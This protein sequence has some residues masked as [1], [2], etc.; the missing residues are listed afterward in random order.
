M[1]HQLWA[2]L[3]VALIAAGAWFWSWLAKR[4]TDQDIALTKSCR[5][6]I[7]GR[8]DQ[9]LEAVAEA[10]YRKGFDDRLNGLPF[11][12]PIPTPPRKTSE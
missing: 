6:D 2:N 1:E 11:S 7:N 3:G 9:L 5:R 12:G 10:A 4:R 8:I